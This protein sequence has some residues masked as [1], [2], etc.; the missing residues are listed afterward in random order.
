M[1]TTTKLPPH[2]FTHPIPNPSH[3]KLSFSPLFNLQFLSTRTNT[4]NG[5]GGRMRVRVRG[6]GGYTKRKLDTEGAYE[7]VDEGTGERVIVWGGKDDVFD[8]EKLLASKEMLFWKPERKASGGEERES[9]VWKGETTSSSV[10]GKT[11]GAGRLKAQKVRNLVRKATR[12]NREPSRIKYEELDGDGD[13]DNPDMPSD[14]D[15]IFMEQKHISSKNGSRPSPQSQMRPKT[16]VRSSEKSS[17]VPS[18]SGLALSDAD[19][20]FMDSK[21]IASKNGSGPSS[22]S[23]MRPKT[24]VRSSEKSSEVPSNSDRAL[25]SDSDDSFLKKK[26][27]ATESGSKPSPESQN[28]PKTPLRPSEKFSEIPSSFDRALFSNSD[29]VF[30]EKK[31]RTSSNGMTPSPESQMKPKTTRRSSEKFSEVPSSFDRALSAHSDDSLI[32]AKHITSTNGSTASPESKRGPKS[33]L[34]S[35]EMLGEVPSSS[36]SPPSRGWGGGQR[37]RSLRDDTEDLKRRSKHSADGGFFSKKSFKVI[38]CSDEV[39]E[40]LRG[41]LFT[42]PSNIQ[43]MAF[44]PALQGKSCI[45]ADQSGSGK[46]LAYLLPIVQRLRQEEVQGISNSFP[47]NPR[48]IV[49]V[50]SNCRSLSKFGIP[51]RSMVA[52]GGFRQK[53]QLENLDLAIDVLIATPGR[54]LHLIKEG[55]VLDEVDI[56]YSDEGFEL[57]LQS[58]T[59]SAMVSTQYL[60][61]TATLP[62][63]VYYKLVEVFPDVE[64]I[65]GPGVHR[66]SSALEEVLVDCSGDEGAEKS[67]E[68]AFTNKKTALLKIAEE[69]PVPKS[70]VF[71]NKIETCRKVENALSRF[72]RRGTQTR[73]IPFHAALAQEKRH[74]N[75]KEFLSPQSGDESQFLICTD[76]ASRG[77]DFEEVDHVI[78]FDF[79]RDPSEYVRRVGRTA[80]GAEGRGKAFVFVVGKQVSLARR[81]M[82]RNLKGHPLH[83]V[84][85]SFE[86]MPR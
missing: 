71:C 40:S 64:V 34:H 83:E 78:L 74:A 47:R 62:L 8:D 19:D 37:R 42:R 5:C 61:V 46:T 43:A 21:H 58:L 85:A 2:L 26:R 10:H 84:P 31:R 72:D 63:D 1:F 16:L 25:S 55:V 59:T 30:M 79:P 66:T 54:F 51:F 81:I 48:A 65:M 15:V 41:Q 69:S 11:W 73:V 23:Q 28:R 60:F 52:T 38:G 80:R 70:I 50:L 20:S 53:T 27:I 32:E 13:D 44:A 49:L 17:E 9:A 67:P 7:V 3:T 29:D 86:L 35:S 36:S 24:L 12:E 18:S 33:S 75:M 57:A 6:V 14:S 22:K 68:T 82:A 77:I 45:I 39:I 56:L 4:I 76:R